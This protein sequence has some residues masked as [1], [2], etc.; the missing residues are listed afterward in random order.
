MR[1]LDPPADPAKQRDCMALLEC[2]D[3]GAHCGLGE[4]KGLGGARDVLAFGDGLKN[5]KLLERHLPF[6]EKASTAGTSTQHGPID[7]L[8]DCID[9][10]I[11]NYSL[12]RSIGPGHI[13]REPDIEGRSI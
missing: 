10:F 12:E 1:E 3:R 8:I 6:L 5:P 2:R 13:T 11:I 4:V 7:K 9:H